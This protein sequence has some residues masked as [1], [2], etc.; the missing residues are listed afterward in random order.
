M[1]GSHL[2]RLGK[3]KGKN[4]IL[5]AMQH[6]KR[7]LQAERGAGANID[8]AKT[9]CNYSLASVADTPE[10][11]ATRA[12]VLMVEAGIDTPR[13]NAVMAVE[14]IYSLPID[15]HN[16]DTRPFFTD[17][18]NW[19]KQTFAGVL[20][21]FDVHLDESAPHAH[22]VILPLV[23]GKMQG[24]DMVGYKGNITRLINLFH[25]EVAGR[26]GL[27][28]SD[29]KRLSNLDKQAIERQVLMRL[30][31]DPVMQSCAWPCFRD[32]IHKD[33]LSFAQSLG[34]AA[35]AKRQTKTKSFIEIMTSK[36]K[37]KPKNPIGNFA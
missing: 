30:K 10:A 12:K 8:A 17:C 15:R 25:K 27:S 13:K 22:A 21:S 4:G 37:G 19:T 11:I 18:L 5:A 36:G 3:V 34:I 1:A 7:T 26:Y 28:R 2:I 6:N 29:S 16:Q 33:P 35:P 14:V 32:A 24:S 31:S 20:L 9:H 23:N